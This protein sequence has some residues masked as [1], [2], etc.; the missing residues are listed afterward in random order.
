MLATCL[1]ADIEVSV[2]RENDVFQEVCAHVM[3]Q[4]SKKDE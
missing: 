2:Q 1:V 4:S 3:G